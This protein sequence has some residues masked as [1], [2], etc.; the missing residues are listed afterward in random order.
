MVLSSWFLVAFW[1]FARCCGSCAPTHGFCCGILNVICCGI[2]CVVCCRIFGQLLVAFGLLSGCFL[3]AFWL[4]AGCCGYCLLCSYECTLLWHM[5]WNIW[6]NV[7]WNIMGIFGQLQ[8]AYWL[9]SGRFLIAG[10]LFSFCCGCCARS[11]AL[12]CGI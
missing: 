7:L 11:N 10:W 12:C 6:W 5:W 3:V 9:H 2:C 4:F 1:L 8:V